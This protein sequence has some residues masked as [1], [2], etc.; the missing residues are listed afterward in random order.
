MKYCG[1]KKFEQKKKKEYYKYEQEPATE[2]QAAGYG[3]YYYQGY[4]EQRPSYRP[5]GYN[6]YRGGRYRQWYFVCKS[7]HLYRQDNG[8]TR[9]RYPKRGQKEEVAVASPVLYFIRILRFQ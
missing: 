3:D 7:E 9:G 4:Y 5:R 1:E 8:P 2:E 6:R